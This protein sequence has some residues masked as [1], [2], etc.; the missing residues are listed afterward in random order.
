MKSTCGS[1]W[2][3]CAITTGTRIDVASVVRGEQSGA[4]GRSL[5]APR[6]E[7]DFL[8]VAHRLAP[9]LLEAVGEIA[10]EFGVANQERREPPPG[11][12]GMIERQH[13]DL[14][15]HDVERVA[16]LARV[17]H[18][19]E[20]ADLGPVIAQKVDEPLRVLVGKTENDLV[21]YPLLG[22]VARDSLKDREPAGGGVL[23][24]LEVAV[25]HVRQDALPRGGEVHE[26]AL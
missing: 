1:P 22:G 10:R 14:F 23:D 19:G 18:A 26:V 7:I 12:E 13:D 11:D 15:V 8:Q 6:I 3:G 20:V 4:R 16:E 9:Q 17:A 21:A 24:G 5:R 2:S 25:L